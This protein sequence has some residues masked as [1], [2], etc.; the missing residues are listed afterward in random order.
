MYDS[1]TWP[2]SVGSNRSVFQH[3]RFATGNAAMLVGREC[4]SIE[5][6]T[7]EDFA[8]GPIPVTDQIEGSLFPTACFRDLICDPFCSR[9]SCDAKPQNLPSAVPHD[10]QS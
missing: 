10:Q 1:R 4:P 6:Y 8:I 5:V 3:M 2:H 9:M 7:D